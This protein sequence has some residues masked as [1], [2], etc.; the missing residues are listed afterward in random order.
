MNK[1]AK[2]KVDVKT[3]WGIVPKGSFVVVLDDETPLHQSYRVQ[4]FGASD[5]QVFGVDKT[6]SMGILDLS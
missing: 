1:I 4:P 6:G 2:L 5:T 3:N